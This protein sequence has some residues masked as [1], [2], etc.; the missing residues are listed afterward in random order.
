MA[1]RNFSL[2]GR[3]WYDLNNFRGTGVTLIS[4][5]IKQSNFF[6]FLHT[7]LSK[8][9]RLPVDLVLFSIPLV[10][11]KETPNGVVVV[12]AAILPSNRTSQLIKVH[13]ENC[14]SCYMCNLNLD[15]KHTVIL[16]FQTQNSHKIK[17]MIVCI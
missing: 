16:I 7:F 11:H 1:L 9:M 5:S 6:R 4:R 17:L 13:S 12:E 8:R 14:H 3:K 15:V 10:V 2:L